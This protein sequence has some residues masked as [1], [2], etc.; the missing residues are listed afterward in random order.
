MKKLIFALSVLMLSLS[1][2]NVVTAQKKG[3]GSSVQRNALLESST[4]LMTYSI[5]NNNNLLMELFNGR[6]MKKEEALKQAVNLENT[7]DFVIGQ[8]DRVLNA[9]VSDIK[10]DEVRYYKDLKKALVV[11]QKQAI[12]LKGHINGE[13]GAKSKFD[14][15][16]ELAW[17][18]VTNVMSK[19]S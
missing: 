15:F 3:G 4:G 6:L 17:K 13:S 9:D 12:S 14:T 10:N 18:Q 19:Q 11:L 16:K 8:V 7:L 5:Y 2:S 1:S